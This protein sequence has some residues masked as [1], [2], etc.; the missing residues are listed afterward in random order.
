[1]LLLILSGH[2]DGNGVAEDFADA[3]GDGAVHAAW[4]T[5]GHASTIGF[6]LFVKVLAPYS[7]ADR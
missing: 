1:M 4:V 6:G 5:V 7:D 3:S 2:G